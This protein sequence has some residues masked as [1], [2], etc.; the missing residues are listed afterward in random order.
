MQRR[1]L[2][3]VRRV[4]IV[5]FPAR[6][7][8]LLTDRTNV[9]A[10]RSTQTAYEQCRLRLA[11]CVRTYLI[12]LRRQRQRIT[13]DEDASSR[14][15][16]TALRRI[17]AAAVTAYRPMFSLYWFYVLT[18]LYVSLDEGRT[19]VRHIRLSVVPVAL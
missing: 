8:H 12:R 16:H 13:T 9:G 19:Q 15:T 1:V 6:A 10:V 17:A 3:F 18:V 2:A 7:A 14:K 5:S 11:V 4:S